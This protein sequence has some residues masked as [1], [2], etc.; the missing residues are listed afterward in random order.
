MGPLLGPF[1]CTHFDLGLNTPWCLCVC[2][3]MCV[4]VSASWTSC[5]LCS[6]FIGKLLRLA[7]KW[8]RQLKVIAYCAY[9]ACAGFELL[10]LAIATASCVLHITISSC[11]CCCAY[12]L[13][14]YFFQRTQTV[15]NPF[16]V[17]HDSFRGF[18]KS[19]K[20]NRSNSR[21]PLPSTAAPLSSIS[22]EVLLLLIKIFKYNV[23]PFLLLCL[24]PSLPLFP[25]RRWATQHFFA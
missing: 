3:S 23:P 18:H 8:S 5:S 9:A 16:L 21:N 24:H 20:K 19:G 11:V 13:W 2:L 14:D 17:L 4:C 22:I 7:L 25:L 15:S 12:F 6:V 10:K 1:L